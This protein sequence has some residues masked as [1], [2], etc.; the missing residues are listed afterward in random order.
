MSPLWPPP[1]ASG[2]MAATLQALTRGRFVLGIGAGWQEDEYL[3]YDFPFPRPSERIEQLGEA[4]DLIRA[5]WTIP[6]TFSGIRLAN[7][8]AR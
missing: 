1:T 8:H 5:M 7:A 2:K 3:A 4:V 6:R